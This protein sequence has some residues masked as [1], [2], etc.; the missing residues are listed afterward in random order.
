MMGKITHKKLRKDIY[1]LLASQ[2]GQMAKTQEKPIPGGRAVEL[3]L[4]PPVS[5]GRIAYN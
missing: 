3:L 5:G 1:E 4:A 2:K